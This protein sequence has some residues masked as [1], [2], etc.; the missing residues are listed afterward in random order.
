MSLNLSSSVVPIWGV[1]NSALRL[2]EGD[3]KALPD[4]TVAFGVKSDTV[5]EG[6]SSEKPNIFDT[7]VPISDATASYVVQQ[8]QEVLKVQE[9]P[10]KT[11]L[12]SHADL[13]WI[14]VDSSNKNKIKELSDP[15]KKELKETLGNRT[16]SR[17]ISKEEMNIS[18]TNAVRIHHISGKEGIFEFNRDSIKK[19]PVTDK[20]IEKLSTLHKSLASQELANAELGHTL[21]T[22]IDDII[23]GRRKCVVKTTAEKL[24]SIY[25]EH[26]GGILFDFN[27]VLSKAVQEAK[28]QIEK[29]R[30]HPQF[31]SASKKRPPSDESISLQRVQPPRKKRR[32]DNTASNKIGLSAEQDDQQQRP[33]KKSF[34]TPETS[35]AMQ[36]SSY[37]DLTTFTMSPNN[38]E[39]INKLSD[40]IKRKLDRKFG[41]SKWQ[42]FRDSVKN[43]SI[44][45]AVVIH[46]ISGKN[47]IF[48]LEGGIPIIKIPVIDKLA[49]LHILRK[50]LPRQKSLPKEFSTLPRVCGDIL[51][52]EQKTVTRQTAE[53]LNSAYTKYVGGVLF[54]FDSIASK[55]I[56]EAE[57][58]VN[59]PTKEYNHSQI[60]QIE[61]D[62]LQQQIPQPIGILAFSSQQ[63]QHPVGIIQGQYYQNTPYNP[64]LF[65]QQNPQQ[66][67]DHQ[68]THY[69]A[70]LIQQQND[71]YEQNN[72]FLS[73]QYDDQQQFHAPYEGNNYSHLDQIATG[74]FQQQT[75]Q[76]EQNNV[77]PSQQELHPQYDDYQTEQPETNLPQDQIEQQEQITD[78]LIWALFGDE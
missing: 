35:G 8:D 7:P 20:I 44:K 42:H 64:N 5:F 56:Q 16:W 75:T 49:E 21:I 48:N 54:D 55:A 25:K 37:A 46:Q 38:R 58:Q 27:S 1:K 52:T 59:I 18:I 34:K 19:I 26:M 4:S 78:D 69:N 39:E 23:R 28:N 10:E 17:I 51:K 40:P 71:Q 67:Y 47:D 65:Q 61:T 74:S 63:E 30:T 15:I 31:S 9:T 41:T 45:D 12:S 36:S 14:Q 32:S 70:H 72:D 2:S 33:L 22:K 60:E 11:Q 62:V 43:I 53:K 3:L 68:E 13:I 50:S 57:N 66:H 24:N 73:K 6:N 76:L 77:V 29:E